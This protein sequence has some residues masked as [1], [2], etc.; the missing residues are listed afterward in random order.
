MPATWCLGTASELEAVTVALQRQ[1]ELE[2]LAVCPKIPRGDVSPEPCSPCS[3]SC[4]RPC[5]NSPGPE[6]GKSRDALT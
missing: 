3:T 2:G 4:R 5:S 1:A 6:R